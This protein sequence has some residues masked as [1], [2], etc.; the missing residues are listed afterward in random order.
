MK[1]TWR[2]RIANGCGLG[3]G[4]SLASYFVQR[5]NIHPYAAGLAVVATG[6]LGWYGSIWMIRAIKNKAAPHSVLIIR[7][8]PLLY[9]VIYFAGVL[10]G[11]YLF[12]N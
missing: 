8:L 1:V 10:A 5:F 12:L 7:L 3:L 2:E 11:S 9:L 4:C 6:P